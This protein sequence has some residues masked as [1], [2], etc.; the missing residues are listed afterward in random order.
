MANPKYARDAAYGKPPKWSAL[1]RRYCPE[2]TDGCSRHARLIAD[3][4]LRNP[5]SPVRRM[6]IDAGYEP[7]HWAASIEVIIEA[8][9]KE[10]AALKE[11]APEFWQ[12]RRDAQYRAV[13]LEPPDPT[14]T[15]KEDHP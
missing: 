9:W 3:E 4:V 5:K 1:Y 6:L 10:R 8:L 13:G 2:H 15:R 14:P 7:D 12:N 11:H